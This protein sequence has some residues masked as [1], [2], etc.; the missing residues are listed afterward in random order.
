[1]RDGSQNQRIVLYSGAG[2]TVRHLYG[3]QTAEDEK[4]EAA[5]DPEAQLTYEERQAVYAQ[6]NAQMR[7]EK[8]H[9]EIP[10]VPQ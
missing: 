1:M 9:L 3:L 7:R 10:E 4:R 6:V 8:N 2:L 5:G